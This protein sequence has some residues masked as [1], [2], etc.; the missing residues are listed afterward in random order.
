[1]ASKIGVAVIG[2]GYWGYKLIREYLALAREY[3]IELRAVADTSREKLEKVSRELGVPRD[4]LY[5]N[6]KE[7]LNDPNIEAVHI[8][9]PNETHFSIARDALE[10]GKN[11]LLEKPMALSSSEAFKLVRFAEINGSVLLVGHIFRFNNALHKVKELLHEGILGELYYLDLAWTTKMPP[12]PGR[13]II[14]DLAPHPVDIFNFLTEEWPNEVYVKARS[15]IRKEKGLEEMAHALL[16]LDKELIAHVKLSWLEYGKKTRAIKIV[17]EK[18]IIKVDALNQEII[19]IDE[20]NNEH[21]V[22]VI[23]NNTMGDMI[24]HFIDVIRGKQ[25]PS[26]S[27]LI[28]A[29]TVVVLEAM[30]KSLER[31]AAISIL[32]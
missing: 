18:G 24:K 8:A 29:L 17:G 20:H 10:H 9:T 5:T 27:A 26:N 22:K 23:P 16:E 31:N 25:S 11:V 28:G 7:I 6:Y 3:G 4:R 1:M 30:R 2:A 19:Y 32:R 13:D 14:F 12:P 21:K 15:Y